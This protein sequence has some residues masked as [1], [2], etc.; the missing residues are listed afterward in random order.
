[1]KPADIAQTHRS[2]AIAP[3]GRDDLTFSLMLPNEW[4][5]DPAS[6]TA[7]GDGANWTTLAVFA[8]KPAAPEWN[9]NHWG[10]VSVLWQRL[11]FEV[12]LD[13]WTAAQLLGMGMEIQTI[14]LWSDARGIVIDAGV[15]G[16]GTLDA[17]SASAASMPTIMRIMVRSDGQDVF[18]VIGM[19]TESAYPAMIREF[20]VAGASFALGREPR[21]LAEPIQ[22]AKAENPNFQIAYPASWVHQAQAV[23]PGITGKSALNLVLV[24]DDLLK[25]FIRIKAVDMRVAGVVSTESLLSDTAAELAEAS[26]TLQQPW[27]P[28]QDPIIHAIP[29]LVEAHLSSGQIQGS[30]YEVHFGA[31]RADPIVF[32]VTALTL[33]LQA[34]PISS[35][36]GHRAYEIALR[37]VQTVD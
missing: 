30:S 33:P 3:Q 15:T 6:A 7:P 34:E 19:A 35:M 11:Q 1:V 20:L 12:R 27:A 22:V 36:R 17:N 4:Q 2:V 31:V 24:I 29:N 37:S 32:C 8:R 13:E 14:R 23:P 5:D 25:G 21:G 10:M 26:V 16:T 18:A 28:L 9:A